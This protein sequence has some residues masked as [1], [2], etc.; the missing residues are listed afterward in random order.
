MDG[1]ELTFDKLTTLD[2]TSEGKSPPPM[3][4]S[5]FGTPKERKCGSR[6][7]HKINELVLIL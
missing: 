7:N 6:A 3:F 1:Q 4:V 5:K 2:I